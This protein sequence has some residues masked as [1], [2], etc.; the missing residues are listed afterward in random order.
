MCTNRK[1]KLHVQRCENACG[2]REQEMLVSARA[3]WSTVLLFAV[4]VLMLM[5]TVACIPSSHIQAKEYL[6]KNKQFLIT[7][8]VPCHKRVAAIGLS[9]SL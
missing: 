3:R 5:L 2:H 6:P 7:R 1:R 8:N 9:L 4:A